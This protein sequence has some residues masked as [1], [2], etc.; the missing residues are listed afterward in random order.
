MNTIGSICQHPVITLD[1]SCSLQEA[2][3]L[4]RQHHVGALV[5]TTDNEAEGGT[6]SGPAT[7]VCGVVTD[8]DL[9]VEGV[10]R[11]LDPQEITVGAICSGKAVAIAA[12]ASVSDAVTLMRSEGVRRL[13]VTGPQRQLMGLVSLDDIV[14]A[15][16]DELGDLAESMRRGVAR[17]TLT[18]R[19][20]DGEAPGVVQVPMEA[21]AGAW[22]S[23]LPGAGFSAT[24][25]L[26]SRAASAGS[27]R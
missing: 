9:A 18:R 20:L 4:M 8:R 23:V 27:A 24:A 25:S 10:A 14:A 5:L 6:L 7:R 12:A 16:A 22:P 1:E 17:E 21:L 15:L 26:S 13:L 11:G 2:A 3:Q 19:P